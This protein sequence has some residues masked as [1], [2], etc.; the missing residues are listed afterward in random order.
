[1]GLLVAFFFGLVAWGAYNFMKNFLQTKKITLLVAFTGLGIFSFLIIVYYLNDRKRW[2]YVRQYFENIGKLNVMLLF[3]WAAIIALGLAFL[4]AVF[5]VLGS[6]QGPRVGKGYNLFFGFIWL[7]LS[8]VVLIFC[9][10]LFKDIYKIS[11]N[12]PMTCN[13]AADIAHEKEYIRG[14]SK[15]C[16]GKYLKAG[17]T[18]RKADFYTRWEIP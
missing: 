11:K 4:N 17:E 13:R 5:N 1:M 10:I 9:A 8:C 3:F 12:K 18:C 6:M 15:F 7:F 14:W 16:N 2:D